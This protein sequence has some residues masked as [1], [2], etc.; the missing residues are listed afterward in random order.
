MYLTFLI[1]T[2]D[3]S[4]VDANRNFFLLG[5]TIY[6]CIF[7][8]AG[9]YGYVTSYF[10]LQQTHADINTLFINDIEGHVNLRGCI[11]SKNKIRSIS[12]KTN[13]YNFSN[14]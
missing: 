14:G 13:Q 12:I 5:N 10:L 6:R 4:I 1:L 7:T 3:Y 8:Q 11:Y 9:Y 2:T